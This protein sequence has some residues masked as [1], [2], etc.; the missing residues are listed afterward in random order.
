MKSALRLILSVILAAVAL[1]AA[2]QEESYRFDIG[3]QIGM[4]GYAG[5]ASSNIFSHPGFAAGASFRYL[6]DVRW[7]VR[8]V[9]NVMG[10]SGDTKGMD[11]VLP[12]GATYN[13][14]S[15]V[16]DLGARVEFNFLPYGIGET[17]K[18]LRRISPYLAAGVGVSLASCEGQTAA[19]FNIPMAFGVKYK[20][21]ERLNLGLEF[22]I[23]KVFSDHI[24]G[25]LADLHQIQTSFVRNTDWYS[26]ISISLTYEFGKRCET[27]HYV[28]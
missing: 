16:Y 5:D 2:A 13:F 4:S 11:D 18:Q 26:D 24:D 25:P 9:F 8:G 23:T 17:Y 20:L 21:R 19:G 22:S 12:G 6:P 15:T 7:A 14:K 1:R 10:L 28:D 27:C 3:G